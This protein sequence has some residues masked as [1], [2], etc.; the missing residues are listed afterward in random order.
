MSV[1][2]A[3]PPASPTLIQSAFNLAVIYGLSGFDALHVA[4]AIEAGAD[5]LITTEKKSKPMFRVR[6]ISVIHLLDI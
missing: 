5:E 4:A 1:Y 6:E 3:F 2:R